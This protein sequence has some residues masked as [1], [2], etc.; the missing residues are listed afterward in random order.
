MKY[1]MKKRFEKKNRGRLKRGRGGK[2]L[3]ERVDVV[4][5]VCAADAEGRA[6]AAEHCDSNCAVT[7][8]LPNPGA[9]DG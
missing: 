5:R 8:E 6:D 2:E 9:R 4:G 3:T 1:T 7:E